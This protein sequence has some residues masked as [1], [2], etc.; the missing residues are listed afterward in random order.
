MVDEF[1]NKMVEMKAS[2]IERL[3]TLFRGIEEMEDKFTNGVKAVCLD[4]IDRLQKEELAEV[5][6]T[7]LL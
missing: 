2:A 1:D 3:T 5:M 6:P 7:A 4:L